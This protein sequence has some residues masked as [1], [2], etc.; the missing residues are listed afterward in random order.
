MLLSVALTLYVNTVLRLWLFAPFTIMLPS[1][2][3]PPLPP[4][5][6]GIV[7]GSPL[8][9]E[10]VAQNHVLPTRPVVMS[11][12]NFI[13]MSAVPPSVSP[14]AGGVRI[15]PRSSSPIDRVTALGTTTR[16]RPAP[17]TVADTA[18]LLFGEKALSLTPVM[19]T[20]PMLAVSP[21][22]IVSVLLPLNI[23][24][25]AKVPAAGVAATVIVIGDDTA[26]ARLAVTVLV[27]PSSAIEAE[28]NIRLTAGMSPVV[29][30][31]IT[32]DR[33]L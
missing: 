20:V 32:L 27:P 15:K 8:A 9:K 24:L 30:P 7:H 4:L 12:D 26:R 18:T 14:P 13:V 3:S 16:F 6:R 1:V 25:P 33:P 19:V 17:P 5:V 11:C 2:L 10:P 22:A 31:T 21:A 29:A 23:K 28:D